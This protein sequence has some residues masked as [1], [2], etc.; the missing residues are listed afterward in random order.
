MKK[1]ENYEYV[2]K[3]LDVESLADWY[4]FRGYAG[5]R[6]IDNIRYYRENKNAKWKLIFFDL[7]LGFWGTKQP[8]TKITGSAEAYSSY[9]VPIR[10]LKVNSQFKQLFLSRLAY[11]SN[12]TLSDEYVLSRIDELEKMLEEDIPENNA[13]WE[14]AYINDGKGSYFNYKFW[15]SQL[16]YLRK[17]VKNGT[18]SRIQLLIDDAESVFG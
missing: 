13:R 9:N 7:D 16:N 10:R 11:H 15:V 18:H 14:Q 2:C 6:D 8:L 4:I 17:I 1:A 5:D 12:N 3:Y